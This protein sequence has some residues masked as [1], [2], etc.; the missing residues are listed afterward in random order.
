LHAT[1]G[2]VSLAWLVAHGVTAPIAS[3]TN[4][5]Q[6]QDL[7]GA[8]RLKLSPEAVRLLDEA[9]KPTAASAAAET[10]TPPPSSR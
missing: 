6:F 2:Q 7:L 3:A 1:P 8:T 9:S 5:E 4:L 10:R